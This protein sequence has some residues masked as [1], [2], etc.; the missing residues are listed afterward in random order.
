[1]DE[2]LEAYEAVCAK[3]RGMLKEPE[4]VKVLKKEALTI[5][6]VETKEAAPAETKADVEKQLKEKHF[7]DARPSVETTDT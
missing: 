4:L 5:K 6:E 7:G 3:L 2:N 1:M